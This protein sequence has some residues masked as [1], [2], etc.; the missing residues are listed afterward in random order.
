M[1]TVRVPAKRIN[2]VMITCD[3]FDDFAAVRKIRSAP[4][5]AI[6]EEAFQSG[7]QKLIGEKGKFVDWGGERNDLMTTKVR[8]KGK[9]VAAAFAFKGP[10]KKGI[11][12]PQKF[13]KNGD[14]IQRLFTSPADI[15]IVQYHDQIAETVLE[16][17]LIFA[18]F[19]SFT[20][21]RRIW[22][23][24]IDG[25]DSDRLIEAHKAAFGIK[26]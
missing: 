4:H 7:I 9:R 20:E 24:Q 14:Q 11:L 3:D 2:A 12:T 8:L 19:K 25:D 1:V 21:G 26:S 16:Q 5:R 13:G 18:Q 23:G 6:S 17:M 10:G 22:F 15:F